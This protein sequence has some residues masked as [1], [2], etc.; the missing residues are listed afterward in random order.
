MQNLKALGHKVRAARQRNSPRQK[1]HLLLIC[2]ALVC[3]FVSRLF[4]A[5]LSS[6]LLAGTPGYIQGEAQWSKGQK[7]ATL[8]LSRYAY[9]RSETD[10]QGYL[11]AIRVPLACHQIRLELDRRQDDQRIIARAF[12]AVGIQPGD[13]DRMIWMY[14]AFRREPHIS[15]AISL[16]ADADQELAALMRNAARLH[17]QI[18]SGSV[19]GTSI[20]Q[21]LSEIYRINTR[22]TPL[23][24]R[25]SQ[26]V[27]KASTWLQRL[28]IF[29]FSSI[30]LLLLLAIAVIC[31]RLYRRLIRSEQSALEA[32]R[33]KSEFLA[34]MSHEIRTPMNGIIGFTELAL[35]TPLTLEQRDY[36]ETVEYSAHALLRI[37]NDILDFSKIEAG[38]LELVR[39]PFSLRA[40]VS[41]AM[42]TI[43]AQAMHK[44]LDLN[45]EVDASAP[46]N[47][48][49]DSTRLRQVL[50]NL[51]GNAVK[52]TDNGYIRLEVHDESV[53]A[54][55]PV[56]HFVVRDSGIGIPAAQQQLIFEPFRQG[57][58]SAR[59]KHGGTGLGLSISARLARSM[60]GA[61]WLESEVGLGSA[62]HFTA[63]FG[64]G[65]TPE[66][67]VPERS[68]CADPDATSLTI[69]VVEDDPVSR[70]LA[71][72]V[73]TRNGHS[74]VTAADGIEALS[75]VEQRPFD[76]ILMDIQMP[77]MDGFEVTNRMRQREGHLVC[78]V[79]IVA[80]TA[81]AM[82]GDR[83]RCLASG[84]DDYI[85]KPF[86]Q[87]QLLTIIAKFT[88]SM[89]VGTLPT[90]GV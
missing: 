52:F 26:S 46:D 71:S 18:T 57:D 14:R 7:D 19:E 41:S 3:I 20:Q 29:I 1:L 87:D 47:L 4:F 43:A 64:A 54:I 42:N 63:C 56:L 48:L 80:V 90:K 44:G 17:S 83:E 27:A 31:F 79:P 78:R 25:F 58:G 70:A 67:A 88:S 2:G 55:R 12:A 66:R 77:D 62:F 9:S 73:L 33:A 45:C 74:V 35:Q 65:A 38:H 11:E 53:A 89:N 37:I 84:M 86:D 69:L 30:A 36:L 32:S 59:R 22:V 49:G 40:T 13:R 15:N 23:E 34:N 39:E 76:L 61:I 28:L 68:V 8:Y 16:W 6:D 5:A 82:K 24:I 60:H 81:N 72:T 21:I 51:L 85:S 75:L 10:Y 50:L